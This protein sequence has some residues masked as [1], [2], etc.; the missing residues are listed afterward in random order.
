MDAATLD[1]GPRKPRGIGTI[2]KIMAGLRRGIAELSVAEK[3]YAIVAGLVIVTSVLLVMS[4]QTV[5]LQTG[6]RH[7]QSSSAQAANNIGRVNGLIYAIVMESRG[8]YMSADW[9]SAEPFAKNLVREL[10]ELQEIVRSW[11]AEAIASQQSN[12][13]ELARRID[14]FVQFRTELVRLGKEESTAAARVFG[15]NDANRN[16]R[17][18]LNES[19]RTV[20]R[21]YEQE[22]GRARSKVEADNRDFMAVLG[23]LAGIAFVALKGQNSIR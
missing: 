3:S 19:L 12:V 16:V 23:G 13:E 21:A 7:L 17:T 22:I 1:A 4:I 9:K 2:R 5:R 18:A 11:K 15:D 6:Y 14:Q 10:P 20:A 8:I